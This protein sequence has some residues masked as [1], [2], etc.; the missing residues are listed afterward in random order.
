VSRD[1]RRRDRGGATIGPAR[2]RLPT[3]RALPPRSVLPVLHGLLGAAL[4]V[5]PRRLLRGLGVP[6]DGVTLV[7][8][9]VLGVRHLAQA[10]T[11]RRRQDRAAVGLGATTD[12]LHGASMLALARLSRPHRRAALASA[13]A[14]A[15][16][17]AI[18]VGRVRRG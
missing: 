13:V 18:E 6:Q 14:A 7:A 4:L 17:A 11:L 2:G 3:G 12:M 9:R 15:T 10:A 1:L 5:A 8:A 16:L